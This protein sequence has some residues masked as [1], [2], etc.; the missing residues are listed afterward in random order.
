MSSGSTGDQE[1]EETWFTSIYRRHYPSVLGY[2]LAHDRRDVAEDI[3]NETFLT[4]WRK[5]GS[6]PADDPLPW[7]LGVARRHRLKLR[8]AGRRHDSIADRVVRLADE[9]DATAWD[10]GSL[11]A[12]RDVGLAAFAALPDRDAEILILTAWY[13]LGPARAAVV[14]GCSTATFFVRLHRARRR[15]A[16]AL[17]DHAV[18]GALAVVGESLEGQH[19]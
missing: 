9:R 5:L 6:V 1:D 12:E 19:R 11:V 16:C 15:L 2:A 14:L 13:G 8:A 18:P 4:A 10:T 3:A 17:D 7:L